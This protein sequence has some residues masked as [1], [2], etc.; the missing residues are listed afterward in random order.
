M[1]GGEHQANEGQYNQYNIQ[2]A[3]DGLAAVFFHLEHAEWKDEQE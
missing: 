3:E 2:Q 1:Y